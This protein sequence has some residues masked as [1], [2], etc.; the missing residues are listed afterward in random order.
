MRSCPNLVAE[1]SGSTNTT[2]LG[3]LVYMCEI[4]AGHVQFTSVD[5]ISD[6]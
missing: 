3:Q 4:T 5:V 2:A 1:A 6:I